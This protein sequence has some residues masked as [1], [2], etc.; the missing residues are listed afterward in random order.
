MSRICDNENANMGYAIDQFAVMQYGVQFSCVGFAT[1]R[2][3]YTYA[4]S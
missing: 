4:Q 2:K 3:L 1:A